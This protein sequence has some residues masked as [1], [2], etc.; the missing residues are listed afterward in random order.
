[1][2]ERYR[3]NIDRLGVSSLSESSE[4]PP[5]YL[6][7]WYDEIMM[8][9]WGLPVAVVLCAFVSALG[10]VNRRRV[11]QGAPW[12]TA[13]AIG[14][15]VGGASFSLAG[16]PLSGLGIAVPIAVAVGLGLLYALVSLFASIAFE[17][18]IKKTVPHKLTTLTSL[19]KRRAGKE[20]AGLSI[21]RGA[22]IGLALLG[23]DTFAIW[24]GTTYFHARL[25]PNHVGLIGGVINF[26]SWPAGLVIGIGAAQVAGIG[27]LVAFVDSVAAR[28]QPRPWIGATAAAALLAA[29]GIRLSMGT[30]QPWYWTLLVL[31]ID[32]FFLVLAFRRFDL[33]TLCVAI[34]VFALWWA[35][36][37]LFV[38][39]QP[40]GA[41]GPWTVFILWGL[42]IAGALGLAFQSTLRHRYR[43]LAAAFD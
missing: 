6:S 7:S 37:P 24:L 8:D 38:M 16:L 10:F 15:F 28:L 41:S 20:A 40:I 22:A 3:V 31:F 1:L 26:V 4:L 5:G 43:R 34:G 19:F 42:C 17:V 9:R 33:L 13:I 39:Q 32:Y 30:I 2:R 21:I 36:Y 11:A 18:L 35:N 23:V 25:S 27:L 12:R 29:S 14:S